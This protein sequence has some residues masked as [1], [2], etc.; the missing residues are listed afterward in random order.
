VK[1]RE[2]ENERER[3]KEREREREIRRRQSKNRHRNKERANIKHLQQAKTG[4]SNWL[5]NL[6]KN[7][8]KVQNRS[9]KT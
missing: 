9:H 4:I 2:R 8:T 3:E 1:E 5:K 7:A 6:H